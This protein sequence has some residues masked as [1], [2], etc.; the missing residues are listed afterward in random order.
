MA[1]NKRLNALKVNIAKNL[2]AAMRD[3]NINIRGEM[4][5]LS[6]TLDK[7]G[8]TEAFESVNRRGIFR[9]LAKHLSRLELN[10]ENPKLESILNMIKE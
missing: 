4:K 3:R 5:S 8:I 2:A 10:Q 6:A 7:L 9:T 1:E